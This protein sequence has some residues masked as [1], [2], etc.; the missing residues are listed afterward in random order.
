MKAEGEKIQLMR[1]AYE[2]S[3]RLSD[4]SGQKVYTIITPSGI[5]HQYGEVLPMSERDETNRRAQEIIDTAYNLF[6]N[7]N[8]PIH[9]FGSDGKGFSIGDVD[10]DGQPSF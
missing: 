8:K 4:R 1:E 3:K 10:E 7:F 9:Y 2:E 6:N 5:N